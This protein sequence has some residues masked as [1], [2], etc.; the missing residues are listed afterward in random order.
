MCDDGLPFDVWKAIR[1][2]ILAVEKHLEG[3]TIIRIVVTDKIIN[4]VTD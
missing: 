3:K 1:L 2:A 4:I